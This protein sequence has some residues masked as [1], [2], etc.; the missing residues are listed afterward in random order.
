MFGAARHWGQD[1]NLG[2][3]TST[4]VLNTDL[5][6]NLTALALAFVLLSLID[7]VVRLLVARL[8][9]LCRPLTLLVLIMLCL[10]I[11][12]NL[13]LLLMKMQ[14]LPLL[15]PLLSFVPTS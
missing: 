8:R 4:H 3:L 10:P 15:K 14:V 9:W 11:S 7:A 13:L 12:E 2:G 1:P 5:L 6:L